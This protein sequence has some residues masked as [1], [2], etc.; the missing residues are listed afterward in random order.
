MSSDARLII[1][2]SAWLT[3][4]AT[5]IILWRWINRKFG[6]TGSPKTWGD[7]PIFAFVAIIGSLGGAYLWN[8]WDVPPGTPLAYI[9]F[10]VANWL[11]GLVAL[12]IL[13]ML[14]LLRGF[15]RNKDK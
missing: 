10:G 13:E 12:S 5:Y 11:G 9:G 1:W 15:V 4:V 8:R 14:G 6:R 2:C 3:A 7:P